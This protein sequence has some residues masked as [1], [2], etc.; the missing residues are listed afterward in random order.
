MSATPI[1]AAAAAAASAAAAGTS[2]ASS[3]AALPVSSQNQFLQLLVTQLKNQD[4]LNPLS[5][6]QM[7][8][9]LAQINMVNGIDQL[10]TTV[11]GLGTN[12]DAG[13]LLQAAG[14]IGH[15]VLV[16]GNQLSL[17]N[18]QATG[19][20]QLSQ[21]VDNLV[22][23][24]LNASGQPIHSVDLGSQPAG[25]V[26]FSWDGKTDSGTT[27]PNG[28]YT[29]QVNAQQ[30]GNSVSTTALSAAQVAGVSQDASGAVTLSLSGQSAV[31]LSS[32]KQIL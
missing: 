12:L 32:V 17:A 2:A 31:P 8:S 6:A 18:G 20:V 13:Q 25:V 5:N 9:Q 27:A 19:G 7:T 21:P 16:P 11:Q 24:V 23:T 15:N 28:T 10:N 3:T 30:G 29:F 14:T 4:P 22:V 26:A 1:T